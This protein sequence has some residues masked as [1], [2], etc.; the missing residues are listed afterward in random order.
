MV[1]RV[2]MVST[3]TRVTVRRDL[4][5]ITVKQVDCLRFLSGCTN[6]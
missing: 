2:K 5:E 3:V 6:V 4:A 1:D